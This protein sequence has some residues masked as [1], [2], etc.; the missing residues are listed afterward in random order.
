M[1]SGSFPRFCRGLV[2]AL[3]G[4]AVVSPGLAAQVPNR[5]RQ[6]IDS[7]TTFALS[8]SVNPRIAAA[9]DTGRLDPST[10][11]TGMT[12]F[13]A[14]TPQQKAALDALVAAQQMPG[15]PN[16]HAW[17]TPAQYAALFGLSDAD[18][19]QIE[20]W[21][22]S[23]GFNIDSV[24]NSRNSLTFSGTAGQVEAAFQTE[25]HHY[26]VNGA[27][28]F[29]NTTDLALP[30]ALA[31]V[32]LAVRNLSD[33]RPQPQVR[34]HTAASPEFTSGQSG[35][36]FLTPKDVA[37]IYDIG[38]AYNSGYN[39]SGETI[40]VV[41]QSAV[42]TSDITSF[43]S[44]AGLTVKSPTITLVPNSGTSAVSQGNEAESDL[45]LEYAGAVAPGAAINFVYVGNNSND[46]VFDALQYV[47][48]NRS[49][50]IINISY[51]ACETEISSSDFFALE[52]VMEQAASQGQSV[53]AAAGDTGSTACYGNKG[54]SLAQQEV[55]SVNYPASSDYVTALGG[56]EFPSADV[57]PSNTTYW[58]SASG[59]DL[60]GS[61]LSYIPEQVWNDDSA[62]VAA[63]Y[64]AQYALSAGGGGVSIL[65][66]RPAWQTGVTGIAS[67]SF[68][69]VPDISLDSSAQNA[70]YLYCTSDTSAWSAGQ[71]ASCNSG[72]RD[73]SSQ[74]LT[75]A[76]GTSFAAPIFSAMLAMIAQKANASQGVA[77]AQLYRL[78]ANG[79]TYASAFHDITKGTN[80]CTAG[81]SYCSSAGAASYAAA[82]GYDEASGLGSVDF[83]NLLSAWTGGSSSTGTGGSG[84]SG[85]SG[86]T[87]GTGGTSSGSFTLKAANIIAAQ[88]GS[89]VSTVTVSSVNPYAGTVAFTLSSSD[90]GLSSDGCYSIN[91]ATVASGAS[92]VAT[93]TIYTTQSACSKASGIHS[94]ARVGGTTMAS[95]GNHPPLHGSLPWSAAAVAGFLLLGIRRFRAR[96]SLFLSCLLLVAVAGLATGCGNN[97]TPAA[98]TTNSSSS[99]SAQLAAGS[100]AV[101]IT[102]TDTTNSAITA[103]INISLTVN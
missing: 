6:G 13:F 19:A 41:G 60:I 82:T 2:A 62:T 30:S 72:F 3:L 76:G 52:N 23:Q 79:T 94:F 101:T 1:D 28:H 10:P 34:L 40:A 83:N 98:A 20:N 63:Q 91:N 92:A 68:R 88:G 87:G 45:D 5:I 103:S 85:G 37:T 89:G 70:G 96:A 99:A 27:Q 102:G 57:A 29:A 38:P 93:L 22:R 39:G 11:I 73:S 21:L 84:G 100:Y 9:A 95:A 77:S 32:V 26:R 36:H 56:T 8:G 80:A 33:F 43:Q 51:G 67:G 61:A 90:S 55:L 35:G 42:A 48:D 65:A 47:V 46:S 58:Q 31:G 54:A 49:A 78:A 75:V 97:S 64:G 16:Y 7:H 71:K 24:A 50:S 53:I 59:S 74:D 69:L 17:I 86:G 25:L 81:L 66:Q 18:L 12:M 14:P 44:A 4:A 15:S